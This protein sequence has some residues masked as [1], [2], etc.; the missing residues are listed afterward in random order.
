MWNEQASDGPSADFQDPAFWSRRRW[1]AASVAT[2]IL[3]NF[4]RPAFG[5][6]TE[7]EPL[8]RFP[9]MVQE[10]FVTQVGLAVDRSRQAYL[11][12][13]SKED[14]EK[15]VEALREKISAS[16]GKFPDRTPLKARVTGKVEYEDYR[17]EKVIFESRPGFPVTA[18][19]YLP[20]GRL[21]APGVVGTCGHSTN[22]KA[23]SAY[24]SFAQGLAKQGYICLLYDPI[25][26]GERLQYV[27]EDLSSSVGP[28]VREHLQAGNQQ[29][30]IGEFLGTWR[31]WDGIRA[32][33]YLAE[34]TEVDNL[35]L[36]V[37]GNSG[38]GTMTTWLTGLDRRWTMSAPSCFVTSFLN[39]MENELPADTE[40]CPP[41]AL[42]LGLD[43][44]DFLAAL[45]P[46]P[47]ILLAKEKD[48][49]DV[50]GSELS[51]A[52]LRRLYALLG[53]PNNVQLY[54]GPTYHGY[55]QENREAMYKFFNAVT[56]VSQQVGE[57]ALEV[58]KD[59]ELWC[60]PKGQVGAEEGVRTVAE[61]TAKREGRLAV[62]RGEV[63]GDE[64]KEK[65]VETLK[66]PNRIRRPPVRI[67]RPLSRRGYP[68]PYVV[69][70]AVQSE[71]GIHAV[72]YWLS[73]ER[74]YSRPPRGKQA[75]LY[76][77]HRSADEELRSEPLIRD[78]LGQSPAIPMIAVDVRGVGESQPNTCAPGSFDS[79]YGCDYFYAIH[80]VMLDRPYVGQKVHDVLS[81]LDWLTLYGYQ[82]VHLMGLGRGAVIAAMAAVMA[83][84]VN[85]VTLKN[86]LTSYHDVATT[87]DYTWP[88]SSLALDVLKH[89]D[90][91]DC[92]RELAATKQ[93][94]QIEPWDAREKPLANQEQQ[95]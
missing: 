20:K 65:I 39:N 59:E 28:G 32:L 55:S 54:A 44:L 6:T 49:F 62:V 40:Q 31:A 2:T 29:F 46:R 41:R 64:L 34:R 85:R 35:H 27:K 76:V 53:V 82:Q 84:S 69:P 36:G 47:V 50:R 68:A 90:L 11:E 75:T 15:H 93:L 80:S 30:L 67:L 78:A 3:S 21:P 17:M 72:A 60:T 95:Q 38:G 42:A 43:H 1:L 58:V 94:E 19:L 8:N 51:L 73:G 91:P 22:G 92:Y 81:V 71:P 70:Y 26:Q 48:Y 5:Q 88:L 61:L 45:A 63:A 87:E 24:Q 77:S 79:P 23:A 74:W 18:N 33:D 13:Q 16:F 83:P 7:F 66:L 56:G 9:R 57:P 4:P 37:T 14:A 10:Y 12:L 52:Y 89:F 25:G 86:S